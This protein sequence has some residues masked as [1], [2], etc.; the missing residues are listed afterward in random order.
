M[1]TMY[2][3]I[4]ADPP[5]NYAAFSNKIPSRSKEG[6]TYNA[7]RMVDIYDFKLLETSK[8]SMLFLWATAPLLPEAIFAMKCWGFEFK[9][10]AFTWIET[11]KVNTNSNCLALEHGQ[12]PI[13]NIIRHK[14]QPRVSISFSTFSYRNAH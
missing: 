6:Q 13:L 9:T 1:Q 14:R 10:V 3:I 11:N 8:D 7:M 2:E 12:D 4:Y 5:W